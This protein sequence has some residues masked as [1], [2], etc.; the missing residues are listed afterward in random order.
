MYNTSRFQIIPSIDSLFPTNSIA[1]NDPLSTLE[2]VD[3]DQ[4]FSARV[5][6]FRDTVVYIVKSIY[7]RFND[8][9]IPRAADGRF[10]R[11]CGQIARESGRVPRGVNFN[12]P[13]NS[14]APPS[15]WLVV[16]RQMVLRKQNE[17]REV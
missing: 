5:R 7:S 4:K 12:F 9:K 8:P 13:S 10:L 1:A 3:S 16:L 15:C 6:T 2:Q 14:R 17:E 11:G